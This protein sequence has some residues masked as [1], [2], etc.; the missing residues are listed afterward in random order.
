MIRIHGLP[1]GLHGAGPD[2][3]RM[4]R[5]VLMPAGLGEVREQILQLSAQRRRCDPACENTEATA[6]VGSCT[7]DLDTDCVDEGT[8]RSDPPGVGHCLG[9][10]WIIEVQHLSLRVACRGSEAGRVFGVP[11]DFCR[12]PHVALDE[13]TAADAV[14]RCG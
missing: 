7:G 11:L 8:P 4:G 2:I 5:L 13:H 9:A 6:L 14:E 3:V 12:A 10:V 1:E